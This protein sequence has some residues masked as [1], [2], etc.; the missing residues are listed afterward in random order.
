MSAMR[1]H[2]AGVL[3]QKRIEQSEQRRREELRAEQVRMINDE[4]TIPIGANWA[5]E[6][7]TSEQA[8]QFHR[9]P[10][11]IHELG[12]HVSTTPAPLSQSPPSRPQLPPGPQPPPSPQSSLAESSYTY[13]L[14]DGEKQEECGNERM[15][16]LG[17]DLRSARRDIRNLQQTVE[18]A[19]LD[20]EALKAQRDATES[21]IAQAHVNRFSQDSDTARLEERSRRLVEQIHRLIRDRKHAEDQLEEGRARESQLSRDLQAAR[22]ESERLTEFAQERKKAWR[23]NEQRPRSRTKDAYTLRRVSS[24]RTGPGTIEKT[25]TKFTYKDDK[26][27]EAGCGCL[28]M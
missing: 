17:A 12:A 22:Q 1:Q 14:G 16:K 25:V 8:E 15:Q 9:L 13:E 7:V 6:D 19:E 3:F 2:P 18:K 21:E 26:E 5:A 28:I 27:R 20:I 4:V 24:R 10:Y 23:D 11:D